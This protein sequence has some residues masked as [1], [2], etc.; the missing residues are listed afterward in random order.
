MWR[1][2]FASAP[3]SP[4]NVATQHGSAGLSD[5]PVIVGTIRSVK[6]AE[7]NVVYL[8]PDRD[9]G[10]AHYQHFRPARHAV[11]RLVLR[12][13]YPRPRNS[14]HPLGGKFPRGVDRTAAERAA[15][16]G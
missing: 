9:K 6:G 12:R 5:P 4:G 14:P 13:R 11:I 16:L 7:A 8:F 2:N 3:N 10:Y 1:A 15:L